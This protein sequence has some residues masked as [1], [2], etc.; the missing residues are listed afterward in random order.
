VLLALVVAIWGTVGYKIWSGLNPELPED[1]PLQLTTN[2]K[3]N[4]STIV[5]TFSI[6]PLERDPFLGKIISKET[7]VKVSNPI[8]KSEDVYIPILYH[9]MI[10]K[11]NSRD[12]LYIISIE[13]QQHFIKV[14]QTVNGIK[15]LKATNDE[16]R[17]T[18]EGI[19]KTILKI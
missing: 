18:Y 11:E 14:G 3:P 4:V 7:N 17:V 10:A 13:N 6:E 15:L 5:D 1:I 19:S 16:I 9:G 2:F 12:K 8:K